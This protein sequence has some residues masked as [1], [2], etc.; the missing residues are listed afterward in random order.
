MATDPNPDDIFSSKMALPLAIAGVSAHL[1]YWIHGEKSMKAVRAWL[2]SYAAVNT[3]DC[4]MPPEHILLCP[5]FTS[6]VLYRLVFHRLRSFPGPFS[7][8]I[9]KLV[10][11]YANIEKNRDVERIWA[12]HKRYGNVIR[13]GPRELSVLDAAAL[14]LIYGASSRCIR[15]P[16]YDRE[17]SATGHDKQEFQLFELRGPAQHAERKKAVWD[18]A[19]NIGLKDYEPSVHATCKEFVSALAQHTNE[20]LSGPEVAKLLAYDLMGTVGWGLT[21]HNSQNWKLNPALE[22][23]DIMTANQQIVSQA[24]WVMNLL[25]NLSS[26]H[27]SRSYVTWIREKVIAKRQQDTP[28]TDAMSK[29]IHNRQA[30]TLKTLCD[31]GQVAI[32]TDTVSTVLASIIFHLA[33][34][35]RVQTKLQQELDAVGGLSNGDFEYRAIS[36]LPY[37]DAVVQ[38]GLRIQPPVQ[39]GI[40]RVTPADGLRLDD[41]TYIPGDTFI[42]IPTLPLQHDLAILF[43]PKNTS[44]SEREKILDR[45]AF[46]PFSM[47]SYMC[48]GRGLAVIELKTALSMIFSGFSARLA[49]GEDGR[50][51]FEETEDCQITHLGDFKVVFSERI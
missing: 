35:S 34:N 11:A 32:H 47:G 27:S 21:F 22:F 17:K 33:R 29:I 45:A 42:S 51:F 12:L 48:V 23:I 4:S 20:S 15:G 9:S 18:K 24:P 2:W 44:Q 46:I 13:V 6:V 36:S 30:L 38:E 25:V 50:K 26:D 40:Q 39:G 5:L 19:F 7:L 14:P 37:L 1:L 49:D 16:W 8:R 10:A 41:G 28:G 31:E 43:S 3:P